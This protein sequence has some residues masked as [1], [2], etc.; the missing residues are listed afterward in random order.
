MKK[1]QLT[2][3]LLSTYAA[4]ITL[5]SCSNKSTETTK[6]DKS[7]ITVDLGSD[8]ATV[9]PQLAEDSQSHRVT[10]DL[11]EGLTTSSQS[12]QIVAGLA[13]K[14]DISPD[15]KTY[16]FHLRNGIKFSD[17]TPIT[18]NDVVYTYRRLVNP[19]VSSPYNM[20]LTNVVNGKAII[21]NK[22]PITSL[23]VKALDK[24]TVEIILE[25]PDPS[26]LA[27]TSLWNLGIVS[28]AN[29]TKFGVSWT[30]PK[31][32]ITSGAYKLDERIIKGHI[33]ESKNPNYYDSNNVAI[34]KV[35]FLPIEDTNSSLSQYKSG[36]LD[37]TYSL[38]VDQYKAVKE[39]LADQEHTV[40]LEAIYYYDFN[41]T[42]P[43]FK[44]NPKLRQALSMAV[45]RNILVKDVLGQGQVPLYSYVTNTIEDGKFAGL[46][47]SWSKLPREKQIA[48]AKQ[49]FKAA[50]YDDSHPLQITI[51]YNTNDLH[52]KVALAISSMWQQTFGV[53]S[54]IV[55]ASNQEWKTF[56]Q[57][58]HKADYDIARDA[59]IADYNSVDTYTNL[60]ECN[61]PQNNAHSCTP[62]FD[63]L[64]HQAQQ[65]GAE[66]QRMALTRQALQKA[67][68]NYSII[69]LYQYTYFRVIKPSVIGY[70]PETNHLDNVYSKWYRF[71]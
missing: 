18:A 39:T 27:I 30:D 47:Y 14:W 41:M 16:T 5:T 4:L 71:N 19:K 2:L 51:N 43:K 7:I 36:G 48:E 23:A 61:N 34:E 60:Y 22:K 66:S 44:N 59:W 33:L 12:N 50:G 3:I 46:D 56:L 1:S 10:N 55:N 25:R 57:T 8:V 62:E 37:I 17:G 68:D 42:L 38:P 21:Q 54:I 6:Q 32:M 31:N 64:I 45:D 11:F 15:G 40:S 65:S 13:D 58:R 9:D 70:T 63:S 35:Q 20:L 69:P 49:L 29:V 53:K 24:N 28:E 67:M 26:F 52:K